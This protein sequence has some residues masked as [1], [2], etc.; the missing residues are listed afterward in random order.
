MGNDEHGP[1]VAP[2]T[3]ARDEVWSLLATALEPQSP[4]PELRSSLL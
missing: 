3:E 4:P 2:E 1:G